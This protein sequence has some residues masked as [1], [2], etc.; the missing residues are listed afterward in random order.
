MVQSITIPLSALNN[1]V[2]VSGVEDVSF[3]IPQLGDIREELDGTLPDVEDIREVVREELE[4]FAEDLNQELEVQVPDLEVPGADAVADAVLDRLDVTEG[5]FGPLDDP[6]DVVIRQAVL[7]GLEELGELDVGF[8]DLDLP[9]LSGVPETVDS[10]AESVDG[11]TDDVSALTEQLGETD[12]PSV[13]D[14]ET[15]TQTALT[16]TLES[17]PGGQLLTDPE[18]FIDAQADRLVGRIVSEES[19]DAL[20]DRIDSLIE[21][22]PEDI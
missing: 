9:D 13:S 11:L 15:A 20:E 22:A 7:D 5:L 10:I 18:A 2:G 8:E 4:A 17:L 19:V 12:L 14:V 21:D 6:L 1:I 3:D 16:E